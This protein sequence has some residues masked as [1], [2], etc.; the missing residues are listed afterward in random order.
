MGINCSAKFLRLLNGLCNCGLI[1]AFCQSNLN[2][3]FGIIIVI[4]KMN[5]EI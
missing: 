1:I 2:F 3:S 4:N 5:N